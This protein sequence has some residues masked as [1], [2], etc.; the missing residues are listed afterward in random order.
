MDCLLD[1]GCHIASMAEFVRWR[2]GELELPER[3][4]VITFDDGFADFATAAFPELESRGLCATVFVPAGKMGGA[5]DWEPSSEQS[6]RPLMNWECV[7]EL[8]ARGVTF[9]AHGV[10]HCDLTRVDQ[11]VAVAEITRSRRII[12]EY[13][14][15]QVFCFAPPYGRSNMPIRNELEKHYEVS[16]GT[17]LASAT[18]DCDVYDVPRVEMHYFRNIRRWRAYL[19]GRANAYLSLRASLRK[20]R[21]VT[22]VRDFSRVQWHCSL[23]GIRQLQP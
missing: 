8:C 1:G 16:L 13:I 9:G 14:G 20:L 17:T 15:S 10:T 2:R 4:V 7:K 19:N 18:R 22:R 11:D 12:E 6:P 5:D 3:A 21:E 23:P